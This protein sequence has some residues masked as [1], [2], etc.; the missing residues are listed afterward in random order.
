MR[1]SRLEISAFRNLT[2]VGVDLV[3]NLNVFYGDNGAGKTALLEAVH[4]LCRGRSFRTQKS[5]GLIQNGQD[6]LMVRG[7]MEDELRGRTTLGIS[8]NRS[9]RTE[10]RLNGRPERRLS[11]IARLTP[12]QV[13]LPDIGELVFGSPSRRRSW[14]DWGTFHVKPD[15]L[16]HLRQFLRAI[17]QR[18]A[19]LRDGAARNLLQP[20]ND[21]AA[22]LG[23]AITEA[24]R[25]YL[26]L[27]EPH[28][29]SVMSVLAPE[30]TVQMSYQQGWPREQ[31]LHKLLGEGQAREVKYG[32]TLWG[33]QRADIALRTPESS[34]AAVLSRG[35][36]KMVASALQ[37][38]QAALLADR[39]R[40][41]T[42]FLIDDAGAELDVAHNERFFGLLAK[43]GGQILATTTRDPR[44]EAGGFAPGGPE[45]V[46]F[47]VEHGS[48]TRM[49]NE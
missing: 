19:L 3:P 13:M 36:G 41:S 27:L 28:F 39:E 42:V 48:V 23:Q 24:R 4:V 5:L 45:Q 30:L 8:R 21:E 32:V 17:R 40:R 18:N 12:L 26:A 29:Q 35:Q 22:R 6:E 44:L 20:W 15:Y 43:I 33:P 11:E 25:A 31:E 46:V 34:A 7:I 2:S 1:F 14:L 37:M 38:A 9:A 16:A 10:L 49:V 47:H